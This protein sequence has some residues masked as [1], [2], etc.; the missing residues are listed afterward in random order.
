MIIPL[1]SNKAVCLPE[2]TQD[3]IHLFIQYYIDPHKHRA[4]EN[5]FCLHANVKHSDITR[6]H[7]LNERIYTDQEL[8]IKS[9]KLVQTVIGRRLFYSDILRYVAEKQI[10][11]YIIIANSDILFDATLGNL[12][13]SDIH[14]EKKMFA[15]LRCEYNPIDPTLS[16]LFGP[17]AD[18][19]DTW[20]FHTNFGFTPTMEKAFKFAMGKPG[21]DN[22]MLYLCSVLG[23]EVINDPDFIHTLHYHLSQQ[24]NYTSKDMIGAPWALS[25]PFDYYDQIQSPVYSGYASRQD[26]P[27]FTDNRVIYEYILSKVSTNSRFI[28][29]RIAGVENTIAHIGQRVLTNTATPEMINELSGQKPILHKHAGIIV[30]DMNHVVE[31]SQRYMDAFTNCEMYTGW[32]KCGSVYNYIREG[33][34]YITTRFSNKKM[35]WAFA[36]DIFHYIFNTP[37]THALRGKRVL[38]VSAFKASIDEK[39]PIRAKLYDGV[40]LFPDCTILTIRPPQTQCDSVSDETYF[41]VYLNEFTKEL[42][43]IKDD[44]DVALVSCGGYGNLVCNHIYNSGK[45]AIYVGGTLQMYFGIL[46]SRWL[47]ERSDILR[48]FLNEHWSRPKESEKPPGH[49]A[50]EKSCYW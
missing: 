48:M 40:D 28:I 9:S 23:Y 18:S 33:H 32:E 47:R 21:C 41:G 24:R 19:Q 12:R 17:R 14:L 15:Q 3:E 30:N 5:K 43:K 49:Q 34:D 31:Y 13:S 7:M 25:V 35:L 10:K 29:P 16:R 46:G 42:D 2:K 6:V 8:G 37:W 4:N 45:S 22:K 20:I 36:L 39:I 11:G 27:Q 26:V 44:Y 50:I 38:I 1:I